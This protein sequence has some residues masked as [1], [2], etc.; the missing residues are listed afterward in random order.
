MSANEALADTLVIRGSRRPL[1]GTVR[2]PGDKSISHR[3]VL[4]GALAEGTT[5]VHNF[6]AANDCRATVRV[7]RALGV[8]VEQ[9]A[10]T[11]LVVHGSGRLTEPSGPLDCGGSGTT[12]RLLA[13]IMAGQPFRS[14]LTGNAQL[15]G[16]PMDRIALPLRQMGATVQGHD[17]GRLAPLTI[18]GGHLH[19][20]HYR[21]PVASG[22]IKSAVLLAGLFAGGATTVEEPAPSRDHT[23]RMLRAMGAPVRR[24]S[25]TAV[26]IQ[27]GTL[28]PLDLMVPGDISS[29]A[30]V[31][32]AAAGRP[33]S[34]LRVAGLGVN[35]TR[36]GLLDV[37][38]AMGV[39]LLFQNVREEHGE[40][41]ADVV[42]EARPLTATTIG[43]PLIPRLID[44]LPV[45]A[46]LATQAQGTTIVRDAAELR[47]KETDRI[48]TVA[49]EL[50]RLGALIDP[51]P[52]GFL[53]HGPTPLT[54]ATVHSHGDHRLA[55]ALAVAGALA[56]GETVV[57]GIAC[58]ADSFPGFARLLAQIGVESD[59]R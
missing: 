38:Q 20:I 30:F 27:A 37:L 54:G 41:V 3:A 50:G 48:A 39:A 32:A 16:R 35:P 6:L 10:P 8:T 18:R 29:A 9:P 28:A 1:G 51:M 52:D 55:M 57:E 4:F 7:V 11:E 40:P 58:A 24:L 53:V 33:R 15:L 22:Q 2:V 19:G 17:G 5:R 14:V 59:E 56:E 43:G 21:P 42:L 13:G 46:V 34:V 36:T 47:V 26:E 44:E 23:E 25:D 45:L 49:T 31:L 12:M